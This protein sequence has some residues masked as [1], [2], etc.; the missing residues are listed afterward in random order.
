MVAVENVRLLPTGAA[1]CEVRIRWAWGQVQAIPLDLSDTDR[2]ALIAAL[3]GDTTPEPSAVDP[4]VT[5]KGELI[6]ELLDA[7]ADAMGNRLKGR[8]WVLGRLQELETT[9]HLHI[10]DIA[11][12]HRLQVPTLR[13]LTAEA[14]RIATSRSG[15]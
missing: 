13:A 4:A 7:A 12:L 6:A 1:L 8:S 3:S 11:H 5:A 14:R 9:R 15:S 2:R 10:R